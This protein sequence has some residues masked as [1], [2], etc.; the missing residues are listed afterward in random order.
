MIQLKHISMLYNDNS[1]RK[2]I[3][4]NDVNIQIEKS[5]F[6]IITGPSG[7]GKSTLLQI[8]GCISKPTS[9]QYFI[10]EN[11]ICDM[12]DSEIAKIRNSKIGFI[13]QNFGLMSYRSVLDNVQIPLLFS[14]NKGTSKSVDKCRSS[15]KK[16]GMEQF[17]KRKVWELSGGE[18][19]RV[20]I[21]R[22]IVNE[23]DII[24]ADEP[25][26]ALDPANKE[27]IM[28]ILSDIHKE[29]RTVVMVTHDMSL[30]SYATKVVR[31]IGG[32]LS[33]E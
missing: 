30:L 10:D 3:A 27:V 28:Q 17:A 9:G 32:N 24:L 31:L 4:L 22:A 29:G 11:N 1:K 21:A 2:I 19:Q 15:L 12:N 20:A 6:I 26:G 7:S 14:D 18:K 16:L 8:L 33:E 25:T 5:D 13:L 23:P